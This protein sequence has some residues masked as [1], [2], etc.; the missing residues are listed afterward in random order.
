MLHFVKSSV[1]IKCMAN[2]Y[3]VLILDDDH[4]N[5]RIPA[6]RM[7]FA[8]YK[9]VKLYIARSADEAVAILEER[10]LDFD[11]ICLDHD[12]N[13]EANIGRKFGKGTGMEVAQWIADRSWDWN[14]ECFML[15]KD[16]ELPHII[17]HSTNS[18]GVGN[19]Y[20][21]LTSAQLDVTIRPFLWLKEVFEQTINI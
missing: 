9:N 10:G 15:G 4:N 21:L 19:M 8:P 5:V 12:L 16:Y 17:L 13:E 2:E 11:L 6:F 1:I 18:L 20:A 3:K 14:N 7:R